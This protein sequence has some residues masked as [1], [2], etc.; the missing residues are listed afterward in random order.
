M[1]TGGST[2]NLAVI[3]VDARTGVI[4]QT[5]RH[6]FLV[7]LLGIKHIA[8]AVNKMDL[9]DFDENV[10]DAIVAEYKALT[11]KLGIEDVTCFPLSA[12]DGDNVVEKSERTPW[13]EALACWTFWR[14]CPFIPTAT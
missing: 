10:F 6:T 12:L 11:D 3:L 8:L 5:R 9:V 13:Y 7:S 2:A 14:P 1:I 4:T